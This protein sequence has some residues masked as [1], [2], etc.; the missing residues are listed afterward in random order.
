MKSDIDMGPSA[1]EIGEEESE[2]NINEE[3]LYEDPLEN[4]IINE[5]TSSK[6]EILKYERND[7]LRHDSTP[8]PDPFSLQETSVSREQV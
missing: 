1:A 4:D 2:I 8:T 6:P 5:P 3:V 7:T